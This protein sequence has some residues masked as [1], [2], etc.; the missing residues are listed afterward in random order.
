MNV[1]LTGVHK[2]FESPAGPVKVIENVS[3]QIPSGAFISLMGPS[4]SGKTTL[5]NLIGCLDNPTFGQIILENRDVAK[6]DETTRERI[7]L[8]HIGF[9]F[10]NYHLMPTLTVQEN[11]MLPM[12]LASLRSRERHDRT[13]M[14]LKAVGLDQ[15][16]SQRVNS[17][18]GG[19]QQRV[20]IA[21]ALANLPRLVLADEPSGNLDGRATKEVMQVLKSINDT[22]KVTVVIVTHDPAVAAYAERVYYLDEGRLT[23]G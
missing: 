18:S 17:L 7:R 10:Q 20:A 14:L 16:A 5:M 9:V 15:R 22:Q 3:L 11:V 13:L 2:Y 6:A 12:Q 21:R 19:Q 8:R 23:T 4:G 1:Q